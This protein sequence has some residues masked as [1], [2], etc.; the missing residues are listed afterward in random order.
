[1][2]MTR[3]S[4]V[5]PSLVLTLGFVSCLSYVTYTLCVFKKVPIGILVL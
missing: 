2:R 4:D 1:M 5:R 3:I